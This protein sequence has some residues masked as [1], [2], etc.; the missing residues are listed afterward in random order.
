MSP[1]PLSRIY[2]FLCFLFFMLSCSST[3]PT[4]EAANPV[5]ISWFARK[6]GFVMKT[7][8]AIDNLDKNDISMSFEAN[9]RKLIF[10][11]TLVWLND[12]VKTWRGR[13]VLSQRDIDKTIMPLLDDSLLLG[14]R[15]Y[16]TVVLDAGHGGS[17]NGATGRRNVQ[18]KRVTLD[19]AKRTRTILEKHG[20]N[21]RMTR[22]ED[23]SMTLN[24]RTELL[25][26]WKPDV[27]VSIH[28]NAAQ[29]T[30]A[31]GIETHITPPRGCA[32]T[33]NSKVFDRDLVQY[34]NNIYDEG[35]MSLGYLIQREL[36]RHLKLVDRGLRRSRFFVTR[37][38]PCPAVLVECGFL[39]NPAE[40]EKFLAAEFRQ[41]AAE[42]IAAGIIAYFDETKSRATHR[43]RK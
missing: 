39:S 15:G 7:K 8:G 21:V 3:Q 41:S 43:V 12:P 27:F 1:K 19:I 13:R 29:S 14:R 32:I 18:E 33:A 16:K 37:N 4:L 22:S 5:S 26:T 6:H 23:K 40:E 11:G 20:I 34:Q 24:N 9:S 2:A 38:A 36:I 42:A 10:N 28:L 25:A 17:D 30:T 31:S 35:N